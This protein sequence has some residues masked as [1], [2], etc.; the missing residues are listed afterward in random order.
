MKNN[1]TKILISGYG[2]RAQGNYITESLYNSLKNSSLDDDDR[3]ELEEKSDNL[4][5]SGINSD[6]F[7]I[8]I[9]DD[10][11]IDTVNDIPNHFTLSIFPEK[12]FFKFNK[13]KKYG[14]VMIEYEKGIW[15]E[16]DLNIEEPELLVFANKRIEISPTTCYSFIHASYDGKQLEEGETLVKSQD[17]YLVNDLGEINELNFN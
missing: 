16:D 8:I 17:F 15:Y 3:Y 4:F 6:T 7:R 10:L 12:E 1:K 2:V 14:L 5:F 9:N 13:N 11:I